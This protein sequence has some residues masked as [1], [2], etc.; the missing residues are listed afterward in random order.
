MNDRDFSSVAKKIEKIIQ[1]NDLYLDIYFISL[2]MLKYL[3]N[4]LI[5]KSL[6]VK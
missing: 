6:C 3:F 1:K 2:L 5:H 4:D